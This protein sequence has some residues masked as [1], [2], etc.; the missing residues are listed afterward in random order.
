MTGYTP[1]RTEE[2]SMEVMPLL[3]CGVVSSTYTR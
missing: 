2:E 1:D 3:W